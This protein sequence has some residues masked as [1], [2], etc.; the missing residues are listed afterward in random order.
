MNSPKSR[1]WFTLVMTFVVIALALF[2]SAGSVDYWQAWVF[3]GIGF[4][5]SA[6]LTSF[7]SRDPALL[8]RRT[9]GGPTSEQRPAQKII[10]LFA[11]LPAIAAFLI[12]GFDRRF[13]WSSVPPS[14]SIFG[15]LLIT[16]SLWMVYRVFRE[17]SF[18][19]ATVEIANDQKVIST[20]PY[21]IIRNPMYACAAVY[22]IGLSLA[23]GS[24]WGLIPSFLTILG[25]VWRLLD[26]ERFLCK[27]LS[28]YKEYCDKVR[29]HLIRGVF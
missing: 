23:L 11:G 19:S 5:S 25:L 13:H 18:G 26:E 28:G 29:W 7:I 21:A 4:A 20:G 6:L 8:E 1:I 3:L 22:F 16:V 10:V 14:L 2:A 24:W 12:P 9:K 17:N 27:N 15:E